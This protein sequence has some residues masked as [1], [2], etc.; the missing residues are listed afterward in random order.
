MNVTMIHSPDY[1]GSRRLV[2]LL[3]LALDYLIDNFGLYSHFTWIHYP[4]L[5]L[6]KL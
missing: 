2:C 3:F 1:L 5:T 6:N 4:S